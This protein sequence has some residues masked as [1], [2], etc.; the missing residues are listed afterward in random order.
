MADN[1]QIDF[2]KKF[3]SYLNDRQIKKCFYHKKEECAGKIKNAHS[4]Q[5]NKRLTILSENINGN[6]LLYSF[7][8]FNIG[9]SIFIKS[10]KP[11]GRAKA[12]TFF[13]F[14][15]YHDSKLF[16]EIENKEFDESAKHCF[17]HSYRSFAHS[18]HRKF[19]ETKAN[20]KEN[21]I[22]KDYSPEFNESLKHGNILAVNDLIK[23]KQYLDSA[24][25]NSDYEKLDYFS[26]IYPDL[27][28]IACS[29]LISPFLTVENRDFNNH[30][31]PDIPYSP[32]M[33]TVLPDFSQTIIIFGCFM[34]DLKGIDF[35]NSIEKLSDYN[36]KRF[37]STM[38]IYFAENTFFSPLIW[39]TL[40]KNGQRLLTESVLG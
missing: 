9:E 21:A 40:G 12:S 27:Y 8:E 23:H 38:L 39:E 19:E 22:N 30:D 31:N 10:L 4:I 36:L 1:F 20:S 17:L 15:D 28:P 2:N 5:N 11:I 16:A 33:L 34:S 35:L 26:I 14:C 32:I 6:D 25:E 24:I 7:T 3:G 37:I 29:S 18:Y 13:G